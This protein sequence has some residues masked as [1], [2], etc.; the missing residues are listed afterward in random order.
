VIYAIASVAARSTAAAA[1]ALMVFAA[2]AAPA[3]DKQSSGA[4][5]A[6]PSNPCY[7]QDSKGRP[8]LLIGDY[9]WHTF[10]DADFDYERMFDSHK[11]RGLN[12]IRVPLF[13]G[14]S[15]SG[16]N[17]Y[18][19]PYLR[20]GPGLAKDG[21]P[22]YDLTRFNE[23]FFHRV[24]TM[25]K[26]AKRRGIYLQLIMVDTC[27]PKRPA[28]WREHAYQRDNN[29]NGMDADPR[30][31]GTG[32]DREQGICSMGNPQA[33]E[34]EKALIRRIVEAVSGCD[35]VILEMA[36]ENTTREWD[37]AMCDYVKGLERGKPIQHLLMPS[38]L[39]PHTDI[40]GRWNAARI[41]ASVIE[42]RSLRQP[43]INDT[44]FAISQNDDEIR[45]VMWTS[46]ASGGHFDYLDDNMDFFLSKPSVD[47]RA[48][49]HKQIDY[50]TA[51]ARKLKPWEMTPDDAIVKSGAAYAMASESELMAYLPSGGSM[52]L[53]LAK[54]TGRLK[55]RWYNPLDGKFG[56]VFEVQAG[57]AQEFKAP[58][59]HD[60]AM[61]IKKAGAK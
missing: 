35:N 42:K 54:L 3:A 52:T 27:T 39:P 6:L 59:D 14:R 50:M 38:D 46:I 1:F 25:C 20:T 55:A 26:A 21:K 9:G 5:A 17:I 49:L 58:N 24:R 10:L 28:H 30:N 15:S 8:V 53:E 29:I 33:I 11:A 61:L 23:Q 44:D 56:K 36:N 43:V 4:L 47:R 57:D 31:T 51:F 45:R 34:L 48:R 32:R 13:D 22:K 7:F 12:L 37:L 60:W 40:A 16:T 2:M 18:V 19:V 41:H